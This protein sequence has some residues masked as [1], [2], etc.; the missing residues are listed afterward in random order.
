MKT[1]MTTKK[2]T[3]LAALLATCLSVPA[4][5]VWA[6]TGSSLG[7]IQQAVDSNS[8]DA[9][10]A[11]V[12]RA[13]KLVCGG[14]GVIL[15]NLID[16]PDYRVRE[17]AAWWIAKRPAMRTRIRNLMVERLTSANG[18][19]ARNAADI[20]G[21]FMHPDAV[22]PISAALGRADLE[23][24]ARV[25]AV[26]ALAFIGH[27]VA[28]PTLAAAT[29]DADAQVRRAAVA[30]IRELR[31]VTVSA[32]ARSAISDSDAGVRL[33]A[34]QTVGFFKDAAARVAL[35]GALRDGDARV[36][37]NAAWALG[38]LGDRAAFTALAAARDGDASVVVRGIAAAAIRNLK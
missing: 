3:V 1:T 8:P 35:E 18:V 32:D 15:T 20:L 23:P 14:C 19:Y 17:V 10:M 12:E 2:K 7:K 34:V 5:S 30:A 4:A 26:N 37:E 24:V 29:K 9:I 11:E 25:A 33:E 36:R 16:H 27:K 21:A 6:G 38:E 31:E 28:L 22:A 13:E